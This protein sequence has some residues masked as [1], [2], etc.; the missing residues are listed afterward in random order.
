MQ[1][2]PRRELPGAFRAALPLLAGQAVVFAVA[3]LQRPALLALL[4]PAE[5]AAFG[6]LSEALRW[7]AAVGGLGLATGVLRVALERPRA[8]RGLLEGS[9]LAAVAASTLVV[10]AL[11]VVAPLVLGD[12][13][14][15][16]EFAVFGWRAPCI[17][18]TGIALAVL[19]AS[20]RLRAKA[21]LD[22]GEKALVLVACIAGAAF[23]GLRG[24]VT[25]AL[26]ASALAAVVSLRVA[27]GGV[28]AD[29]ERPAGLVAAAFTVGRAQIVLTVVE[30][31]RRLVVLRVAEI[32]GASD[33]ELGHLYAAIALTL[34][35]VALPEMVAQGLYPRMADERGERAGLDA[36][37]A[38][39]LRELALVG[40]PLLAAYGG[41]LHVALPLLR[42]GAY[43]GAV[44]PALALLPGVLAH[45]LTA[46]T[47]YVVL[48]R[49]RLGRAALASLAAL[50]T[51][52][53]LA[54]LLTPAHGAVGGAV[55][56]SAALGVRGVLLV[57]AAR[58]GAS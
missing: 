35:L 41:L 50:V 51:G 1:D 53:G 57:V 22:A 17:A 44:L 3:F 18:A 21:A 20:G 30:T 15:A 26:A 25:A 7:A 13:P 52:A 32:R 24:L 28:A 9:A 16:H 55:A 46:H 31:A 4:D 42:G 54:W 34:P 12:G 10:A 33:V 27:R 11:L 38:R 2:A 8:R 19:H 43:E 45:G 14:A 56:L 6:V 49:R 48:V 36:S 23:D 39:L 47:G 5:F 37:H 58:G 40:V 29:D